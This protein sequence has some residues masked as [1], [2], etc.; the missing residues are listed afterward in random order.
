MDS[1]DSNSR[2]DPP[3]RRGGGF[4]LRFT[5]SCDAIGADPSELRESL[6]R[7]CETLDSLSLSQRLHQ[8]R[9]DGSLSRSSEFA[10]FT[11]SQR[12]ISNT[13][14][15]VFRNELSTKQAEYE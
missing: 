10:S 14:G 15:R 4:S 1:S 8:H 9:H 12:N 3:Q 6:Q 5:N 11:T 2:Q 7:V 13:Q